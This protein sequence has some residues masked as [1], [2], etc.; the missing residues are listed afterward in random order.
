MAIDTAQKIKF[1]I[2]NLFSKCNQIRSF[3]GIWSHILKESL[4]ESFVFCAMWYFWYAVAQYTVLTKIQ[5]IDY[6]E[7][8]TQWCSVKKVFLKISKNS[9]ENTCATLFYRTR[10][11]AASDYWILIQC[12]IPNVVRSYF[13]QNWLFSFIISN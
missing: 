5:N 11:V 2:K 3:L 10:P 6:S 1:S 9:Q 8:V 7:V 13:W 12:R 4:M